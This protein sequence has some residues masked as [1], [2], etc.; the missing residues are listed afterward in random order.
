MKSFLLTSFL[1]LTATIVFSQGVMGIKQPTLVLKNLLA[2]D[3]T[4]TKIFEIRNT[5]NKPFIITRAT[6]MSAQIQT[7]WTREPIAPGKSGKIQV[8]FTS[9]RFQERFDY[10]IMV[11]TNLT[12]KGTELRVTGNVIDNP[13][14]PTLLY[15]YTLAGI[16][17]R[18]SNV[19]FGNI[20]TWQKMVDTV[21]YLNTR[22]EPIRIEPLNKPAYLQFDFQPAVVAP[23]QRGAMIITFDAP[24]RNYYGYNYDNVMLSVN[25]TKDFNNRITV[26]ANIVEDFSKLTP[27]ELDNA[28]VV[29][30][31]SK[32]INFGEIKQGEKTHCDFIV[33]NTGKRPLFIRNTKASCGCTAVTIGNKAV[34]PG[35]STTIRATF[36]SAGKSGRQYK[37]ITVI[38]NDPKHSE[39]TLR[40]RGN[41]KV[42]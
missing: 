16:K 17:F 4:Q 19:T 18:A 35:Q 37:T 12:N 6:S 40:I 10:K 24:K 21:Y 5:G 13:A 1:L 31:V 15:K 34:Q 42:R 7:K 36:D 28:P 25:G 20:Y 39:T 22:N 8:I 29:E 33:K 26:T 3:Q 38:T 9:S 2:D 32:E 27:Q 23:N 14:K 41:I 11:Y 30:F